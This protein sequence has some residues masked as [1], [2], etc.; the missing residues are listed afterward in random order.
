MADKSGKYPNLTETPYKDPK[1][2]SEAGKLAGPKYSKYKWNVLKILGYKETDVNARELTKLKKKDFDEIIKFL[3][4]SDFT[5]IKEVS[6][7]KKIPAFLKVMCRGIVKDA[8]KG[9]MKNVKDILERLWGKPEQKIEN[10]M[11]GSL[12]GNITVKFI[13]AKKNTE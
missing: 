1:K 12:E 10:E 9:E 4:F 6:D 7:E 2:A 3:L 8:A 11:S 5:K 13:P